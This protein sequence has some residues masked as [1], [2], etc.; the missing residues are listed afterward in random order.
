MSDYYYTLI[1]HELVRKLSQLIGKAYSLA[2]FYST[3]NRK[4]YDVLG[5]VGGSPFLMYTER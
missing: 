4:H 2:N 5:E 1:Q 3:V